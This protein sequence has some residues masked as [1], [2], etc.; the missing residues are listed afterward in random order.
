MEMQWDSHTC[1]TCGAHYEIGYGEAADD[2]ETAL[3]D[4]SCPGCGKSVTVTVPEHAVGELK[5][6]LSDEEADEGG[7]G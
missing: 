2:P 1:P 6:E 7:G 3:V 5:I 4:V